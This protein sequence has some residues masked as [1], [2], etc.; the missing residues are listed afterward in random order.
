[1]VSVRYC[2]TPPN[3]RAHGMAGH[4]LQVNPPLIAQAG[5]GREL[6]SMSQT[7]SSQVCLPSLSM[8]RVSAASSR[9]LR[10]SRALAMPLRS[11]RVVRSGARKGGFWFHVGCSRSSSV[12]EGRFMVGS[13]VSGSGVCVLRLRLN[14]LQLLVSK[15]P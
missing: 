10:C 1:M 9:R 12:L 2:E 3:G 13:G 6:Q 8:P 11:W 5:R 15:Y 14:L 7:P 4:G